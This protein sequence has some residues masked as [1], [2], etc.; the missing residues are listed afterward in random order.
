MSDYGPTPDHGR[1]AGHGFWLTT[2]PLTDHGPVSDIGSLAGC[3]RD[4]PR[5]DPGEL[6]QRV[7]PLVPGVLLEEARQRRLGHLADINVAARVHPE[8]M[9]R[10]EPFRRAGVWPSPRRENVPLDVADG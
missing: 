2:S 8:S 7:T 6:G 3:T 9:R 4:P 10:R 1:V 5:L